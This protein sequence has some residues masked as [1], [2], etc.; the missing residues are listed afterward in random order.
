MNSLTAWRGPYKLDKFCSKVPKCLSLSHFNFNDTHIEEKK[1]S[2]VEKK[3][4]LFTIFINNG[5]TLCSREAT[6]AADD[7]SDAPAVPRD[8]T[9]LQFDEPWLS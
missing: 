3:N 6:A 1:K 8:G 7:L 4:S 9:S 2:R 5:A